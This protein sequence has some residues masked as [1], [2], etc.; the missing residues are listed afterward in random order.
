MR[1][2]TKLI[3]VFSSS[4]C[5][6][7]TAVWIAWNEVL[8]LNFDAF[9]Q[10]DK[11]ICSRCKS[12]RRNLYEILMD[13]LQTSSTW[14][15]MFVRQMKFVY[16]GFWI[17]RTKGVFERWLTFRIKEKTDVWI[18][19][20]KRRWCSFSLIVNIFQECLSTLLLHISE[21]RN[22]DNYRD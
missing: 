20:K 1:Y 12:Y 9:F 15:A 17:F 2:V 4:P 7:V 22:S 21:R 19:G 11:R 5:L 8:V 16:T 6:S 13:P 18:H 3:Y 14:L 10:F